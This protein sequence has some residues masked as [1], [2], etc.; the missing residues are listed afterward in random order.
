MPVAPALGPVGWDR[1]DMLRH[2]SGVKLERC[3][4]QCAQLARKA[5]K[6][7]VQQP[8]RRPVYLLLLLMA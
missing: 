7:Y 2:V 1:R 4:C 3:Q 5:R 6:G 8:W